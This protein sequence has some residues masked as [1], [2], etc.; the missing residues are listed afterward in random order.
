[1]FSPEKLWLLSCR[2]HR[3]GARSL[4]LIVKQINALLYRNSLAPWAD[5][6][7]DVKLGH[8]SLATV[9]HGRVTIG[10]RVVI[11]HNV[12]LTVRTEAVP[13]GEISGKIVVEDGVTIGTGAIVIATPGTTLRIGENAHIGAGAV[14]TEDVP[15]RATVVPARARILLDHA[16]EGSAPRYGRDAAN[17]RSHP[18]E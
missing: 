9:V 15:R 16:P 14:V 3:N 12:T 7:P 13:Q 6:C 1:V 4:A 2:L 17:A 8:L 18:P 5:V 10:A 11:W